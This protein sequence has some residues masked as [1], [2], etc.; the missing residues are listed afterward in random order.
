LIKVSLE[1]FYELGRFLYFIYKV[2]VWLF[3]WLLHCNK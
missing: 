1:S 2:F 3:K